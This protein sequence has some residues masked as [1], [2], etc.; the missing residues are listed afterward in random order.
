MFSV[1]KLHSGFT[2]S[3]KI[4]FRATAFQVVEGYDLLFWKLLLQPQCQ[5]GA[6]KSCPAGDED[7]DL[8]NIIIVV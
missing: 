8:T 6:N 1:N 3:R 4:E 7:H 2:K 5:V